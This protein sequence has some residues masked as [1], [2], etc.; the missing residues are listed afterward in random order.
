MPDSLFSLVAAA[1]FLFFAFLSFTLLIHPGFFFRMFPNPLQPD[2][3]WNRVQMR[4]V[5]LIFCLMLSMVFSGILRGAHASALLEGF[6]HNML[7][8][9]WIALLAVP[10]L[11]WFLWRFSVRPITRSAYISG[12]FENPAWE[13]RMSIIFCSILVFIVGLA[14]LLAAKGITL[15][16]V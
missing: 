9:L 15:D 2:T 11:L 12:S 4:G 13:R 16:S 6:H 3:P 14:W 1:V 10:I 5:G 8:A 7:L